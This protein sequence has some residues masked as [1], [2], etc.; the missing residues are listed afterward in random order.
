MDLNV[1]PEISLSLFRPFMCQMSRS[2]EN[3]L[4]DFSN[5]LKRDG[6]VMAVTKVAF[7]TRVD[8]VIFQ[9]FDQRSNHHERVG[10]YRYRDRFHSF[11]TS[12]R[13]CICSVSWS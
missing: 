13:L 9:I 8:P 5:A 3:D 12:C 1:T 4:K 7:Y 11:V 10:T 6:S 2:R